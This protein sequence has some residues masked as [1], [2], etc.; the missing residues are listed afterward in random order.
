MANLTGQYE[1]QHSPGIG[2]N[3]F[4]ARLDR[5][6][7]RADGRF[8]LIIQ[9]Q[10]RAMGAAQAWIKGEQTSTNPQETR[11]E[12]RYTVHDRQVSLHFDDGGTEEAQASWNGDGIQVGPNFFTKVSSSTVLPPTHRIKQDMEDIAK[13]VKIAST[14]GGF[15]M[16]AAKTF[17]EIRQPDE[18]KTGTPASNPSPQQPASS[19]PY[20]APPQARFCDRCG[21]PSRPDK[22]FCNSCGARLQ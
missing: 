11:R 7:L 22:R 17:Q 18:T 3:Y 1:C 8:T 21:A 10:S 13:G 5:L 15:A 4:T 6:I 20:N 19:A 9:K 14:L 12:G 2:L 16:K